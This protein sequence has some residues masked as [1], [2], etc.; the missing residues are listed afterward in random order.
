MDRSYLAISLVFVLLILK[1]QLN[2]SFAGLDGSSSSKYEVESLSS[3]HLSSGSMSPL[4]GGS[5]V[6]SSQRSPKVLFG[7]E[8]G[9]MRDVETV[10]RRVGKDRRKIDVSQYYQNLKVE[11]KGMYE[12]IQKETSTYPL[13]FSVFQNF[14][15][16]SLNLSLLNED[17]YSIGYIGQILQTK[18]GYGILRCIGGDL[19]VKCEICKRHFESLGETPISEETCDLAKSGMYS[20]LTTLGSEVLVKLPDSEDRKRRSQGSFFFR[21][22]VRS[23]RVGGGSDFENNTISLKDAVGPNV[24]LLHF[25]YLGYVE[26]SS[27]SCLVRWTK[28][29]E[30]L[31]FLKESMP[32]DVALRQ[33]ANL[34]LDMY[35]SFGEGRSF[36]RYRSHLSPRAP[37]APSSQLLRRSFTRHP[38]FRQGEGHSLLGE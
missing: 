17:Y 21:D 4:K 35:Q 16:A 18:P 7:S 27:D 5:K 14:D 29:N 6:Q 24:K 12:D 13:M 9:L 23:A 20:F 1:C 38:P 26:L 28:T 22:G 32:S 11:A 36:E 30:P 19:C 8:S 34:P 25:K 3:S 10:L 2:E 15:E 33:Q 37:H 31:N